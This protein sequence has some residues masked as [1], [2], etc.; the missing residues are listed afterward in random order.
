MMN[1]WHGSY[2]KAASCDSQ[3]LADVK[4]YTI[5]LGPATP[6]EYAFSLDV[7]NRFVTCTY[8]TILIGLQYYNRHKWET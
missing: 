4:P 5:G 2:R 8:L 6:L 3:S 7:W 1:G